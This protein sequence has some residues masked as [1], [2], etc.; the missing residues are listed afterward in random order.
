MSTTFQQLPESTVALRNEYEISCP[1]DIGDEIVTI[2]RAVTDSPALLIKKRVVSQIIVGGTIKVVTDDGF[3][4]SREQCY[5]Y[6]KLIDS[7]YFDLG[8][9]FCL[10]LTKL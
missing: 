6:K 1:F 9:R 10:L 2:T 7:D 3:Q 8:N 5:S 4:F